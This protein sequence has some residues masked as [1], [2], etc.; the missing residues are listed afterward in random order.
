MSGVAK[1]QGPTHAHLGI[2]SALQIQHVG[3]LLGVDVSV[4]KHHQQ[5]INVHPR[6]PF[7]K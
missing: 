4:W 2:Q 3:I 1:P 7:Y 5:P 6:A